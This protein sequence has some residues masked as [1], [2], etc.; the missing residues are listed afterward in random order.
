MTRSKLLTLGVVLGVFVLGGAT[1]AGIAYAV[2]ERGRLVD[3]DAD[4]ARRGEMRMAAMTRALNLSSEQRQKI[5]AILERQEPT[6]R[7][8]MQRI[9]Q[10]CGGPLRQHKAQLDAEI[11]KLLDPEQQRRFDE[12]SARQEE[13]LFLREGRM[14]RGGRR[15]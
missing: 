2:A 14:H 1:G 3:E 10:D 9:M 11:K 13:R 5:S 15:H 4:F 8:T 7:Q 6:R 12:L